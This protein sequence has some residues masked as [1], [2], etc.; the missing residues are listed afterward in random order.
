[1]ATLET[2]SGRNSSHSANSSAVAVENLDEIEEQ[3]QQREE[4]EKVKEKDGREDEPYSVFA[5]A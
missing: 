3:Q 1:V 4:E 2:Y 5:D